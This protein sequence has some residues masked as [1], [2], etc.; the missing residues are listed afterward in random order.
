MGQLNGSS[1]PS[2]CNRDG[3]VF[4]SLLPCIFGRDEMMM[5]VVQQDPMPQ[6]GGL[7]AKAGVHLKQERKTTEVDLNKGSSQRG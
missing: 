4:C 2:V 7:G 5:G 3:S 1:S 6:R